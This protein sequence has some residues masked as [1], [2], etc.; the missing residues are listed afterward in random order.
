MNKKNFRQANVIVL[1]VAATLAA[2]GYWWQRSL[3]VPLPAAPT[4]KIHCLSYSPYRLAGDT[5]FDENFVVSPQ[6]VAE[7]FALLARGTRCVRTYSV[8][9]GLGE[10]P[11]SARKAGLKVWLGI[12][13]GRDAVENRHEIELAIDLARR[14]PDVIEALIVGNEVLLRREKTSVELAALIEEVRAATSLPVTYADVWEF[15]LRNPSLA[16]TVDFLTVHMLPYWE[17]DPIA[18]TAAV[19][20]AMTMVDLVQTAFPGKE[21]VVGEAGWPSA[22]R[23]RRAAA[24]GLVNE[25]RFLREFAVQANTRR[26][27]YNLIEAFD[28]PWKR[29]QEGAMGGHWGM[30]DSA[31]RPKFALTG[32]VIEDSH[33]RRGWAAMA[34]G[35]LGFVIFAWTRRVRGRTGMLIAALAGGA[36]GGTLWAQWHYLWIWNRYAVEWLV[37]ASYTCAA[38]ILSALITLDLARGVSGAAKKPT[39]LVAPL[40]A[41]FLFGAAIMS[42]LLVVDARYRG[43]PLPLHLAPAI[44]LALHAYVFGVGR[45]SVQERVLAAWLAASAPYI[46]WQEGIENLP[47]LVW[48]GL[49]MLY[50]LPVL[51]SVRPLTLSTSTPRVKPTAENS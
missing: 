10:V 39:P 40:R 24:P 8:R 50:A 21:I 35:A 26:L 19:G 28:Q 4:G 17:D 33:W 38:L 31:G 1:L 42:L 13:I 46:V 41:I 51:A 22:G 37:T 9:Q 18:V 44:G 29:G 20:H 45:V 32:A 16:Q 25:A 7:D 48:A 23:W 12:W 5:P 43:F 34:V 6:R 30:F 27:R 36:V 47:G 14:Y 15:W 11:E 2:L 49:T 3:A